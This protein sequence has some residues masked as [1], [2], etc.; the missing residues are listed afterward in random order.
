MFGRLRYSYPFKAKDGQPAA[1]L[2]NLLSL[3]NQ[4]VKAIDMDP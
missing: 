2:K 3:N 4:N 1:M